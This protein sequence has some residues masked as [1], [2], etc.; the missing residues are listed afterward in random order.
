MRSGGG[1]GNN[2]KNSGYNFYGS[3]Q[4]T[5]IAPHAYMHH[6]DDSSSLNDFGESNNPNQNETKIMSMDISNINDRSAQTA[7][8]NDSKIA[9]D[10]QF[11]QN[12]QQNV[13]R[14]NQRIQGFIMEEQKLQSQIQQ[15]TS[16]QY[17]IPLS[18]SDE[19]DNNHKQQQSLEKQQNSIRKQNISAPPIPNSNQ[20]IRSKMIENQQNYYNRQQ[21]GQQNSKKQRKLQSQRKNDNEEEDLDEEEDNDGDIYQTAL[22]TDNQDRSGRKTIDFNPSNNKSGYSNHS[23]VTAAQNT[24]EGKRKRQ[25]A[26][27]SEAAE[28]NTKKKSRNKFDSVATPGN[29]MFDEFEY[30][31]NNNGKISGAKGNKDQSYE[32]DESYDDEF[33][34]SYSNKKLRNQDLST[35]G[36]ER[37][38]VIEHNS[39]QVYQQFDKN[40]GSLPSINLKDKFSK[41]HP[42]D[43]SNVHS[44]QLQTSTRIQSKR[45]TQDKKNLKA[46]EET[47][48]LQGSSSIRVHTKDSNNHTQDEFDQR[49]LRNSMQS[50]RLSDQPQNFDSNDTRGVN[51]LTTMGGS[52]KKGKKKKKKSPM[53]IK[54]HSSQGELDE[55]YK[56]IDPDGPQSNDPFTNQLPLQETFQKQYLNQSAKD[57]QME[58]QGNILP[59]Q[60]QNG[61]HDF[62][63]VYK[64]DKSRS[65]KIL[66]WLSIAGAMIQSVNIASN[67]AV[68]LSSPFSTEIVLGIY[69]AFLI[70]RP[71]II[72]C[73]MAYYTFVI[74][75]KS[76]RE[77][78]QD[79]RLKI[80][81]L[82]AE[83]KK[84][85]RQ[86]FFQCK[87]IVA[88]ILSYPVLQYTGFTRIIRTEKVLM[89]GTSHYFIELFT[90]TIPL[91]LIHIYNHTSSNLPYTEL[92]KLMI[93]FSVMSIIDVGLELFIQRHLIKEGQKQTLIGRLLKKKKT[94]FNITVLSALVGMAFTGTCIIA[95]VFGFGV[96]TC[97]RGYYLQ[98]SQCFKCS[99]V[100]GPTCDACS[101]PFKCDD[102][103]YG[104]YPDQLTAKCLS[105]K[106]TT[107]GDTCQDCSSNSW[108]TECGPGEQIVN[109]KCTSCSNGCTDCTGKLCSSCVAGFTMVNGV[110]KKCEDLIP[111]CGECSDDKTCTKCNSTE[112]SIQQNGTCACAAGK[113]SLYNSTTQKCDCL[114]NNFKL[115]GTCGDCTSTIPRCDE[116][117]PPLT[118]TVGVKL[119]DGRSLQCSNCGYYN[120]L[121]S[122][123]YSCLS[124]STKFPNCGSC[125]MS[126]T[127]CTKCLPTHLKTGTGINIKCELCD[128]YIRNCKKCVA[129]NQCIECVDGYHLG[130]G[131]CWWWFW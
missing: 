83:K 102:C 107:L 21:D 86:N 120:F 62:V 128:D 94:V 1:N 127:S 89:W 92:D 76:Y 15:T 29:P 28:N 130:L 64:S 35:V 110:C 81:N 32:Q 80:Q 61:N 49:A 72:G 112:F 56:Q 27:K 99:D 38:S 7:G 84:K 58:S 16:N 12:F 45:Q 101:S 31:T 79:Y 33:D 23:I 129:E 10:I 19:D 116:C 18:S 46:Y 74:V 40:S 100:L 20:A 47:P 122:A 36:N 90:Q 8:I 111:F 37:A 104:L 73:F 115:N 43:G 108:C 63:E 121:R 17:V 39:S 48:N 30:K 106:N 126:G 41:V 14:P 6:Q 2:N 11:S 117:S 124:C 9:Q 125:G 65:K 68:Y 77:E 55:S 5:M 123:N 66:F 52:K 75:Q 26:N 13:I 131:I 97:P 22:K 113:F 4:P 109:G 24:A 69:F 85:K 91:L 3:S 25:S 53:N 95:L 93:A 87:H 118:S 44:S 42:Q 50:N 51:S 96:R 60:L 88:Y 82:N 78:E 98:Q 103:S 119:D 71:I 34:Q 105:C 57:D 59:S 114:Q 70:L 54:S 67:I